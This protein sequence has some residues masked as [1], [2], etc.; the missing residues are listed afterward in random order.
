MTTPSQNY[1]SICQAIGT[2]VAK[3]VA[4]SLNPFFDRLDKAETSF[5]AVAMVLHSLP[6]FQAL[7]AKVVSQART[8]EGLQM[9]I[10][11][12]M[13]PRQDAENIKL[14]VEDKQ[15]EPEPCHEEESDGEFVCDQCGTEAPHNSCSECERDDVCEECEGPGGDNPNKEGEQWACGPCVTSAAK[16]D[17]AGDDEE[18]EEEE[19]VE[20]EVE[21]EEEEEVEEDEEEEVV[22]EEDDEEEDEEEDVEEEAEEEEEDH[23]PAP[24]SAPA[25]EPEQESD[26]EE[27]EEEEVFIVVL[28]LDDKEVEFYTNDDENG[29]IYEVNADESVGKKLGR[30]EN[31]DPILD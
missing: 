9:H 21:A 18:E 11:S 16:E 7:E 1:E 20:E 17:E 5:K 22:E 23:L 24:R 19:E 31:G 6:E 25:Q 27:S 2:Q 12:L 26:G 29:D 8:I 30:F 13:K 10:N 14:V 3:T 4:E 15:S 28:E